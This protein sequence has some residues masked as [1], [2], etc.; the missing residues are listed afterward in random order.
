MAGQLVPT[1]QLQPIQ[2]LGLVPLTLLLQLLAQFPFTGVQLPPFRG[3]QQQTWNIRFHSTES[4]STMITW[5]TPLS[6]S[7]TLDTTT[8]ARVDAR[9]A[10]LNTHTTIP[11]GLVTST[12]TTASKKTL[13]TVLRKLE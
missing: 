11:S 5:A 10:T 1:S 6:Q 2:L 3:L 8:F 9:T 13:L 7:P 12:E 4:A